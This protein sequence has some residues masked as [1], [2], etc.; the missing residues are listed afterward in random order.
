MS[1]P[2]EIDKLSSGAQWLKVDLHVHTPASS[3]MAKRW[4]EASPEDVVRIAQ[5]KQLDAIAITDHNTAKWCDRVRKAAEDTPLTVFPGVEISTHQGHILAIFDTDV[6]ATVIEDLLIRVGFDRDKFGSLDFATEKGIVDVSNC[7][8][9]ADGVAVAA[10]ADG[11]RGFLKVIETG[12]ERKRAYCAQN[13]RALEILDATS[14]DGHQSGSKHGRRM[15]CIQ[16]SDC[17]DR[18]SDHHELD[19]MANRYSFLKIDA[20]T[21]AGSS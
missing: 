16:S 15:A 12:A 3:D 19:A 17:S 6:S 11:P 13:L 4:R 7:I 9:E 20:R 1:T 10:H 8:A 2:E 21:L 14:R 18:D 5:E